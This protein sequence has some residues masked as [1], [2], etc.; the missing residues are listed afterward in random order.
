[1]PKT[2][3]NEKWR[4]MSIHTTPRKTPVD[5]AGR[6]SPTMSELIRENDRYV[7]AGS[8]KN[9]EPLCLGVLASGRLCAK[10]ARKGRNFCSTCR[11]R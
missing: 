3:A 9:L 7:R 2:K 4:S 5:F 11:A 10:I 8:G 6:P 1:M